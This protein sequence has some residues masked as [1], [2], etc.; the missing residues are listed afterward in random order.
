MIGIFHSF[1]CGCLFVASLYAIP[2]W[3]RSQ[4]RNDPVHVKYRIAVVSIVMLVVP[5]I[6]WLSLNAG[7]STADG[8]T[9]S[10][11]E[12]LTQL[13]IAPACFSTNSVLFPVIAVVLLFAG[14]LL[15]IGIEASRLALAP[16][17]LSFVMPRSWAPA[18]VAAHV[19]S[20]TDCFAEALHLRQQTPLLNFR[21]LV[22]APVAEEW[23][24]RACVL[25]V[26]VAS[27]ASPAAAIF[28]SAASFGLAH[29]HHGYEL[30]RSGHPPAAVALSVAAQFGYTTLFGC[31]A[32]FLLLYSGNIAGVVLSHSFCN[33]M[34]FPDLS[35]MQCFQ[36]PSSLK[37]DRWNHPLHSW[38]WPL[39]IFYVAGVVAFWCFCAMVVQKCST[40][41]CACALRGLA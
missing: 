36:T 24:F 41:D 28:G 14:P 16:T 2:A 11:R 29:V 5:F 35:W 22:F 1:V 9:L 15:Q 27:G 7:S 17:F 30:L 33:M 26:F 19:V 18:S 12:L 32:A 34:G 25:P 31:I 21:A 38:R 8:A 10:G 40:A 37:A 20:R 23:V 4:P 3:V 6:T 13:G 39:L